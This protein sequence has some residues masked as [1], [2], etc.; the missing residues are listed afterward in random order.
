MLF[1]FKICKLFRFF[2]L[3]YLNF[4][5]LRCIG[6]L[7]F[8]PRLSNLKNLLRPFTLNY[9]GFLFRLLRLFYFKMHRLPRLFTLGYL[10]FFIY[11][12]LLL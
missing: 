8:Y 5:I 1:Y 12:S 2:I 9:L 6:Y 7:G 10:K 4:F 3:G 11:L